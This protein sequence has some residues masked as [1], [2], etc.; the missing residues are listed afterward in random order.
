MTMIN[1]TLEE[2]LLNISHPAATQKILP[3]PSVSVI[4]NPGNWRDCWMK[5][6]SWQRWISLVAGTTDTKAEILLQNRFEMSLRNRDLPH[7]RNWHRCFNRRVY[8][9]LYNSVS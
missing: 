9:L 1:S 7:A 8:M 2:I 4:C 6:Q 3:S 5:R